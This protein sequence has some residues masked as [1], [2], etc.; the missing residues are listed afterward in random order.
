MNRIRST[1]RAAGVITAVGVLA[2]AA[3]SATP[4]DPSGAA[5]GE[6]TTLKVATIGLVSDGALLV[7]QEQGFFE[8][9]G[10]RVE[11]SVVANPPAGLA[12]AQGGQVDIAYAPSIPL[13]N[14]LASGV[15]LRVVAPADGYVDGAAAAE[16]PAA[17]DDTGLY[18][19]AASGIT[20]IADLEGA[21]IAIPA[22]KAQLEVVVSDALDGEGVDPSSVEWVVLDFTSA[23]AALQSGAVDAA[24]LVSPFTS[25]A[26]AAGAT[27]V[28][29]PSVA[30]FEE[31]SVGLWTAGEGTVSAKSDAIAA[32]QR[33][34]A[35]SN[36]YA[37][38][39]PEEAIQAGIDATGSALDVE[40]IKLPFWPAQVVPEELD[41]VNEKLVALGFLPSPVDLQDVLVPAE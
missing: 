4:A 9:E 13:L 22:R 14:A 28:S 15:P 26:A 6:L 41:R 30:F 1:R 31:G 36:A 20:E 16:D 3:C 29:A 39:H 27:F 25:E 34:V 37:N 12:A 24:G 10:L 35:R 38:E 33:A 5:D 32:F 7:G 17:V 40:D 21:T 19:S 2:L 11:T 8:D 18:A 23:V